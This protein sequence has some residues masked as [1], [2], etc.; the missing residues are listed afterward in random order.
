MLAAGTCGQMLLVSGLESSEC[1]SAFLL[2]GNLHPAP[3]IRTSVFIRTFHMP[4]WL[5][6]SL[7]RN[8]KPLVVMAF[9]SHSGSLESLPMNTW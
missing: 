7:V 2:S 3:S 8:T 1:F 6:A 4:T 9:C 5:M